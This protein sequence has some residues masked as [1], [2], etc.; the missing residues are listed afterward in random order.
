MSR[1]ALRNRPDHR[2]LARDQRSPVKGRGTDA[3]AMFPGPLDLVKSMGG[4]HE[5]LLRRAAAVRAGAAE[6]AHLDHG[7][8]KAGRAG[9]NGHPHPRIAAAQ[10]DNVVFLDAHQATS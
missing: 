1:E 2:L 6:I 7:D 5:D 3:Y 4:R 8:G 9:R 10:D